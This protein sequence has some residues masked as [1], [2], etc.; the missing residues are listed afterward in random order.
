M[1]DEGGVGKA[2]EARL[3]KTGATVLPLEAGIATAD[4][5]AR[6]RGWLA[7]G[8]VQGVYWLPALD[9]E[10]ALDKLDLAG[11]RE[12]NRRRVKNLYTAMRALYDS[13]AGP[14]AFLV[15]A[16]RLGGLHGYGPG[17][18]TA[19]AGGGVSG[20]TKAYAMEQALRGRAE[21]NAES[22]ARGYCQGRR[23]RAGRKAR[24]CGRDPGGRDAFRP[25]RDRGWASRGAALHGHAAR[26]ARAARRARLAARSRHGF[27]RHRRGGRHHERNRGR[28]RR[29]K[30]GG[31]LPARPG[32]AARTG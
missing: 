3:R 11:W 31:L 25:R 23:L 8:P 29:R 1:D 32:R 26:A 12:I 14:G 21:P 20:F 17:G 13:V 4:L 27:P 18:A 19:P 16:T 5:E 2:L 7:E 22:R 28:P 6:L 30:P 15:S 24:R 9:A 10:P